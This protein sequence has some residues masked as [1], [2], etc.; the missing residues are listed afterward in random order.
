MSNR[1]TDHVLSVR[2]FSNSCSVP[3]ILAWNFLC[4]A[5]SGANASSK[6]VVSWST[7]CV[8]F[9]RPRRP[10]FLTYAQSVGK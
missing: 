8:Y 9:V 4:N 2:G 1:Q 10:K 5:S 3:A 7:R 6:A